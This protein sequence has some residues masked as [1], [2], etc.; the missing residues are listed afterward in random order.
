MLSLE[1]L[2]AIMPALPA[3]KGQAFL[4]FFQAA[5]AEFAIETPA[6]SAAFLAQVA[7]ESG[8][9]R[10]MEEI[11]GPTPAQQR[12]EPPS[13]L[14]TTLG[15]TEA[16]DG[17]R[18]KG[19]GPIQITGPRE[20]P[21]VRRSARD[22]SRGG[23]CACRTAGH[24][25]QGL[26]ALLGEERT[27][28]AGGSGHGRG[29]STDHA[30]DQRR[31]ERSGRSRAL[32]RRCAKSP[33]SSGG[34]C[35]ARRR[36]VRHVRS[37]G[38]LRTRRRG[39]SVGVKRARSHVRPLAEDGQAREMATRPRRSRFWFLVFGK[40]AARAPTP[41]RTRGGSV[42]ESVVLTAQRGSREGDV[43]MTATPGEDV[44]VIHIAGGPSLW[45]HPEHARELLLAQHDPGAR[46]ERR[47]RRLPPVT[48]RFRHASNG[49]SRMP[50]PPVASLAGFSVTC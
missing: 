13:S 23:P 49:G 26:R 3:A 50:L 10:F 39:H 44:V 19:R 21:P 46:R 25:L 28:R 5:I 8:Q 2:H 29:I 48:S 31:I 27:E 16:G 42:K 47:R 32:L 11:W 30:T 22:R 1:Q 18:F 15:N 33:R 12:Y 14:A 41:E 4:P 6:R 40:T 45:L 17:R 34:R 37:D 43:R 9:F 36:E 20:L 35:R 38:A 7:H 24:G